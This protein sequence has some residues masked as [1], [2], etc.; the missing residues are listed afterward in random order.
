MSTT[1]RELRSDEGKAFHALVLRLHETLRPLEA[2]LA[3]GEEIIER[4]L[5]WLFGRVAATDGRVLVAEEKG[6]LIGYVV[7][8]GRVTPPE[9]D[10][11]DVPHAVLQELFVDP[12]WR[13]HGLGSL[14]MDR[15][16]DHAR[17]MGARE[18]RLNAL[19]GNADAI[20]FYEARGYRRRLVEMTRRL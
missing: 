4:H 10:E 15:A 19:A 16:E 11:I 2:S 5:A 18:V 13:G 17:L 14:L 9:P 12:D 1:I 7:V 20:D 8:L 3:P 6:V